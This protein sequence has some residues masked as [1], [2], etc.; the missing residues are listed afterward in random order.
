M[1]VLAGA[2]LLAALLVAALLLMS[3]GGPAGVLAVRVPAD[4]A[5]RQM[6][7]A[8]SPAAERPR[9]PTVGGTITTAGASLDSAK[10]AAASVSSSPPSTVFDPDRMSKRRVRRGSDPIH[11]KC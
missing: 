6:M 7:G 11:N 9:T 10:K 4:L 2:S 5:D 3:S 1:R 8:S